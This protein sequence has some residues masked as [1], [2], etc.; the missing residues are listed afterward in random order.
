M[1]YFTIMIRTPATPFS[2][3]EALQAYQEKNKQKE[4]IVE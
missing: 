3:T 1:S 2:V 4:K